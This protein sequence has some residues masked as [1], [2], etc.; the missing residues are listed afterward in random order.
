[1]T[2]ENPT[3]TIN[4]TRVAAPEG[5]VAYKYAD[6]VEDARWLYDDDYA[7]RI[8]AEDPSLIEWVK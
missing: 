5:A 6:P 4:G 8:E 3:A 2:N 7:R 1:M